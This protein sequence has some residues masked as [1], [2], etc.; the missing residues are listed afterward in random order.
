M[1]YSNS[2]RAGRYGDRILVGRDFPPLSTLAL[3]LTKPPKTM[4]AGVKGV[5]VW[6]WPPTLSS[7]EVKERVQLYLCSPSR[8]P[9]P[10]QGWNLPFYLYQREIWAESDNILTKQLPFGE[11]KVFILTAFLINNEDKVLWPVMNQNEFWSKETL[12]S[13]D[14]MHTWDRPVTRVV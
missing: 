9:W 3:G 1:P 4:G 8:P 2:L 7:V 13:F 14:S 12:K 5:G 10:V 11:N 6:L